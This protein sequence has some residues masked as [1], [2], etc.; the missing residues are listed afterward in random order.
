MSLPISM[1][2]SLAVLRMAISPK[3]PTEVVATDLPR[4]PSNDVRPLAEQHERAAVDGSGDVDQ[5]CAADIG[6]DRG[7]AALVDIHLAGEECM[8]RC[9]GA[10]RADVDRQAA[11]AEVSLLVGQ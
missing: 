4:K 11:F 1:P 6:V 2:C 7:G 10:Q 5:V 8:R 9:S 3:A